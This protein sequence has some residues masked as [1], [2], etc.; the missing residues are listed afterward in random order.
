[1][2]NYLL[3]IV[4]SIISMSCGVNKQAD[5]GGIPQGE[6]SIGQG[7]KIRFSQ[8]NLQY[9]AS[10]NTWRFAEHQ[11]EVIGDENR[12]ISPTYN[13]WI[14]LFGWGTS[15]WNNGNTFYKPTDYLIDWEKED[16]GYGPILDVSKIDTLHNPAELFAYHMSK[17]GL[18]LIGDYE[19][20]DWGVFN[21]ISNGGN[22][23][24]F[25]RTLTE[26]EWIYLLERR[27]NAQKKVSKAIVDEVKGFVILPDIWNQP[28][29][30]SFYPHSKDY[31]GNI[32]NIEHW[33]KM[34]ECGAVFLPLSG[35][36]TYMSEI[37]VDGVNEEFWYW[38]STSS[39]RFMYNIFATAVS[40]MPGACVDC[41]G[42]NWTRTLPDFGLAVRLVQ[43]VK[44]E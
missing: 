18:S 14:D 21:K 37:Y 2:I 42:F 26:V 6:F 4:I 33:R 25:W 40:F 24:G 34:E 8:G 43:D 38:S 30:T 23:T 9:R 1:M 16:H 13:G 39:G 28:T 22:K 20:A 31:S 41:Y 29:G 12:K 10:T 3:S 32:Y 35:K 7:K 17:S 44:T 11:W 15:G 36:R 27:D 19:N 5:S